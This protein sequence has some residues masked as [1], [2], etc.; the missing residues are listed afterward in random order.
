[1]ETAAT[2]QATKTPVELSDEQLLA[3]I[4]EI[5]ARNI[6]TFAYL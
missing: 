3:N 2:G 6:S 5:Q 1:M 4:R